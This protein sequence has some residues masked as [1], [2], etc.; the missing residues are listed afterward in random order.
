MGSAVFSR[1]CWFLLLPKNIKVFG[2]IKVFGKGMVAIISK[3][4]KGRCEK[5]VIGKSEEVCR[6]YTPMQLKYAQ[7]LQDDSNIVEVK[8]NVLLDGFSE[9]EF[10]TDFVCVKADGD[11]MVREC[12]YRKLLLKP[13]TTK[14]LDAS[15]EYWARHGV[16]DW[17]LVV[18]A[19]E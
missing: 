15:R 10:T 17:G 8:C 6:A 14:L 2:E 19:K 9:G 12:V 1:V 3:N 5:V 16:I 7:M 18:D 11:L 4:Y 13:R